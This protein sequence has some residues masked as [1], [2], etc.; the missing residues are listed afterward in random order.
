MKKNVKKPAK[1]QKKTQAVPAKKVPVKKVP[2]KK[3]AK[4]KLKHVRAPDAPVLGE[5][6]KRA[7]KPLYPYRKWADG[8]ERVIRQPAD[9]QCSLQSMRQNLAGWA[10]R[11]GCTAIINVSSENKA[12]SFRFVAAPMPVQ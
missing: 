9:F 3:V 12:I 6:L 5:P 2:A 11:N 10:K 8:N 7:K 1:A 4:S